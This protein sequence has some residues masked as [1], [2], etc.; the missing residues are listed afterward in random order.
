MLVLVCLERVVTLMR[1][2]RTVCAERNIWSEIV[3]DAPDGSRFNLVGD[4]G[5]VSAR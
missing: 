4:N 5:T 1:D 2:R 3:L